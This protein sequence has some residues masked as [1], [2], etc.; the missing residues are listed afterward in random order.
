MVHDPDDIGKVPRED[1]V[2][3]MKSLGCTLVS[4][5]PTSPL[6]I[7]ELPGGRVVTISYLDMNQAS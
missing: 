7:W 6:M 5:S 3:W 2:F 4:H 1:V